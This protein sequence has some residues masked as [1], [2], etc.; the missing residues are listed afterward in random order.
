[1]SS[2]LAAQSFAV[3]G[4]TTDSQAARICRIRI[5]QWQLRRKWN[6]LWI[7]KVSPSGWYSNDLNGVRNLLIDQ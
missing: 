2:G 7:K 3:R 6:S 5:P 1:M 4:S